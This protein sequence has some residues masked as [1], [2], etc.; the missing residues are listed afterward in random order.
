MSD[1]Q[2][3]PK[4]RRSLSSV[5]LR[6]A[7]TGLLLAQLI[8][9]GYLLVGDNLR[10]VAPGLVYRCAQ[11]SPKHLEQAIKQHGIRTVIN[12]RGCC[13]PEPWY[14]EQCRVLGRLN[15]SHEDLGCSAGRLLSTFTVSEL[16]KILDQTEYPILVH[17][18]RGI[19]RT[20]LVVAVALLLRTDISLD[21]AVSQLG[22]RFAHLPWGK[23]GNMDRFFDLYR[24]W[25][26]ATGRAHSREAF[27][28]WIEKDY[29][30]GE[31]RA[32]IEVLDM[33]SPVPRLPRDQPNGLRVR[34]TN[35]SVKPWHFKPGTNAGIHLHFLVN[36]EPGAPGGMGRA[37]LFE[38]TVAPGESIELTLALPALPPGRYSLRADLIDEQH[39]S[40]FQAGSEPLIQEVVVE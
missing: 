28:L 40:F 13:E 20:G 1:S 27:R 22:L 18:H 9:I 10:T 24:E 6:G 14:L 21:D 33:T 38:A 34:C 19:D 17:C 29:C 16:V 35:T 26:T 31:C 12:L 36:G 2:N 15:V 30:P 4:P 7:V 37:G 39:A 23:T 11:L 5:L 25:L 3:A 32:R 8:E